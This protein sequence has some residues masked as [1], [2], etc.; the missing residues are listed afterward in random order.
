MSKMRKIKPLKLSSMHK[1][2]RSPFISKQKTQ[3][4]NY[5]K[6]SNPRS[7]SYLVNNLSNIGIESERIPYTKEKILKTLESKKLAK[8]ARNLKRRFKEPFRYSSLTDPRDRKLRAKIMMNRSYDVFFFFCLFFRMDLLMCLI[9][10]LKI[11]NLII[12]LLAPVLKGLFKKEL[13][14]V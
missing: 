6:E 12:G 14:F 3:E 4:R 10:E 2:S 13:I 1:K 9:I 5:Y 11:F 7:V 8:S